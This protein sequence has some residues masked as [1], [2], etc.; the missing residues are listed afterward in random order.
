MSEIDSG[1]LEKIL[2]PSTHFLK[3][4]QAFE[5]AMTVARGQGWDAC[6]DAYRELLAELGV[7]FEPPAKPDGMV[8]PERAI[9]ELA[10]PA[11]WRIEEVSVTDGR[12]VLPDGRDVE[13]GSG[14]A[15]IRYP[16]LRRP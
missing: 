16:V 11:D 2:D 10:E 8:V 13:V 4:R 1:V 7:A 5:Q 12:A 3:R 9:V 14:I 15:V 6:D